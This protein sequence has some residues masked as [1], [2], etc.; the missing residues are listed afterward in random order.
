MKK[1][2]LIMALIGVA[3]SLCFV[4]F[5][6]FAATYLK[7]N[8][9]GQIDFLTF[10][11]LAYVEEVK[12][13][14]F[15]ENDNGQYYAKSKTLSEFK[16]MYLKKD[17][18]SKTIDLSKLTIMNGEK[19]EIAIT[20]MSLEKTN[21]KP[22]VSYTKT[23]DNIIVRS[24]SAFLPANG[25]QSPQT[26]QPNTLKIYIENWDSTA[27]TLGGNLNVQ[28]SFE[29]VESLL[30]NNGTYSFKDESTGVYTNEYLKWKY[31]S[32]D[33]QSPCSETP[34]GLNGYYVLQT[35]I[36]TDYSLRTD[37]EH[38]G[39]LQFNYDVSYA[40]YGTSTLV[41]MRDCRH[42][43][44]TNVNVNDYG[45]SDVRKY[46]NGI[47]IYKESAAIDSSQTDSDGNS[48]YII[49][50]DTAS[51][52]SNMYTDLCIDTENDL[53]YKMITPRSLSSLYEK[54]VGVS[55]EALAD[56]SKY[57]PSVMPDFEQQKD[58][59]W[60]PSHYEVISMEFDMPWS[61]D[62][63]GV[64]QYGYW[65]RSPIQNKSLHLDIVCMEEV[66]DSQPGSVGISAR[67]CF[68]I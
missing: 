59:F 31:V 53:V 58:K 13:S 14:N 5:G 40:C 16:D 8:L 48:I 67:P 20:M 34:V 28:I 44:N 43:E 15:V 47:N 11:K 45:Y 65:L 26:G 17:T 22:I 37:D 55:G 41:P 56:T 63:I 52:Y 18:T 4:V 32:K 68:M 12:I 64:Y 1:K 46:V 62:G 23:N 42:L 60:I 51:N 21:L 7:L 66:V 33:G 61:F 49:R 30:Q 25:G 10:D 35:D 27:I 50:P 24:T 2:S 29:E 57:S 39:L 9:Q 6:V 36:T 54:I 19:L 38:K 3:L